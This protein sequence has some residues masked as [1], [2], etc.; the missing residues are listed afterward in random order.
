MMRVLKKFESVDKTAVI[1]LHK[2]TLHCSFYEQEKH[3][4][5]IEYPNKSYHYVE[6]A[7]ENWLN[8]VLTYETVKTYAA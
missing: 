7:A 4:G 2:E 1:S 5:E 8:G 3:V 6:D